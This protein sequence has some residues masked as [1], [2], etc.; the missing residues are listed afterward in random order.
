MRG[1]RLWRGGLK[2]GDSEVVTKKIQPNH[3]DSLSEFLQIVTL[4]HLKT[5]SML[6]CIFR[7]DPKKIIIIQEYLGQARTLSSHSWQQIQE[8]ETPYF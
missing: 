2:K 3:N 1:L 6:K 8:L 7:Q 4:G 5:L